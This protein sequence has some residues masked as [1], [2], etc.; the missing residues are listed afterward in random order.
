MAL[1]V[2]FSAGLSGRAVSVGRGWLVSDLLTMDFTLISL[3]IYCPGCKTMCETKRQAV[4][5]GLNST[6]RQLSG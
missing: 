1:N 4:M 3:P 6:R 2:N 5:P